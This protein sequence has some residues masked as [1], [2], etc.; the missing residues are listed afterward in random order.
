VLSLSCVLIVVYV[1]YGVASAYFLHCYPVFNFNEICCLK[2]ILMTIGK[3]IIYLI[4]EVYETS[5][6]YLLEN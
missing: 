6:V 2:W 1:K 5:I 4:P 3:L